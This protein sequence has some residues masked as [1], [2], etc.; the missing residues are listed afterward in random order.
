MALLLEGLLLNQT[1]FFVGYSLRDPN[2]QQMF[3]RIARMLSESHRRAFAVSFEARGSTA[4][5]L[6]QQWRRQQLEL[7]SIPG[8]T[9]EEQR[10]QFQRF[11]DRLAE[12]V[13]M[14]SPPLVLAPDVPAPQSLRRLRELLQQVG[15]EV[16]SMSQTRLG[17]K[18]AVL[19]GEVLRFLTAHG[20]RPSQLGRGLCQVWEDLAR[21][22]TATDER[23][24]MLIAALNS[25]EALTDVCR[26]REEL[27]RLAPPVPIGGSIL[28]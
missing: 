7:I 17:E 24:R 13:T 14:Q 4:S 3:G 9:R 16:E 26:V 6:R 11:L 19:L 28:S 22:T 5:Y 27:A 12:T 15:M 18:E 21:H 2:F 8:E 23:Q 10:R 1:F 25:A 20:W